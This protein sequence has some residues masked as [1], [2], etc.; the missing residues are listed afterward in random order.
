MRFR[1]IVISTLIALSAGISSFGS[2]IIKSGPNR[3]ETE[4]LKLEASIA[5][6]EKIIF[7]S[8]PSLSGKIYV[9]AENINQ[10]VFKYKKIL[11]TAEQSTAVDYAEVIVVETQRSPDGLKIL[12]R[13]PNPAPWVGLDD[14]TAVEG[15]LHLPKNSRIEIDAVYFDV[16][17]EGPF[18]SVRNES[19]LG[20]LD[21]KNVTD[22]LVLSSTNRE[23]N[24]KDVSGDISVSAGNADIRIE[25]M[26]CDKKAAMIKND[27]GSILIEK[28][29]GLF[30]IVDN[31]G[32]IRMNDIEL[33]PGESRIE[34]THCPARL[35]VRDIEKSDLVMTDDYES[36]ELILKDTVAVLFTLG[37]GIES[38]IHVRGI[39]LTP[40]RIGRNQLEFV[41]GDSVSHI[42]ID[43]GGNGNIDIEGV[44][45][46]DK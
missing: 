12:L 7:S 45:S 18:R 33:T 41:S 38:E 8:A 36:V 22:M 28:A 44:S 13:A 17:M 5:A 27:N 25:N 9:V 16:T 31:Y 20:R 42:T 15:E 46:T 39:P 40:I 1:A 24:L 3:F 30:D 14:L 37:V 29:R 2:D 35:E 11:R 21:I 32:K 26:T 34:G 19:S 4:E 43:V 23:I 6:D 10:V